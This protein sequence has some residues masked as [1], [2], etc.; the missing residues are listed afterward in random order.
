MF[1]PRSLGQKATGGERQ[2]GGQLPN[3]IS[4]YSQGRRTGCAVASA[5]GW[6]G[7][8]GLPLALLFFLVLVP[9]PEIRA[10][11]RRKPKYTQSLGIFPRRNISS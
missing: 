5:L 2:K 9:V 3:V 1:L 7:R 4:I 8:Q 11:K 6:G 10:A